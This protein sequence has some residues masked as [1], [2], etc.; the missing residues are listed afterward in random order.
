[1]PD[2][3]HPFPMRSLSRRRFLLAAG[4]GLALSMVAACRGG[5]FSLRPEPTLEPLDL[6]LLVAEEFNFLFDLSSFHDPWNEAFPHWPLTIHEGNWNNL[7]ERV[8]QDAAQGQASFDGVLP[9]AM[10]INTFDWLDRDLLQPVDPHF[11]TSDIPGADRLQSDLY[12][13]VRDA[14]QEQGQ[15]QGIP[16]NV[17][18]VALAWLTAPLAEAGVTAPPVTWDDTQAA[19]QAVQAATSL[20]PYDRALSP[21]SDLLAMIWSGEAD[22][23]TVD[24]LVNWSG[25]TAVFAVQWLQDMVW[26]ELMP[27]TERGFDLWMSGR[28]A[29]LSSLDLM[30]PLAASFLGEGTVVTGSNMRLYREEARAGTPFWTNTLAL[31]RGAPN[32]AAA[33]AFAFWW[34]GP[35]NIGHQRRIADVA[36]KPAYTYVFDSDLMADAK[37]DW[38]REAMT[39][40]GASVRLQTGST[41]NQELEAVVGWLNRALD[42][43][44]NLSAQEAMQAAMSEVR[45]IRGTA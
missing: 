1:M 4:S 41:W 23:Y 20:V 3:Q 28:I 7:L 36:A 19:A 9:V 27:A 29:M 2:T 16:V 15:M 6:N 30:G 24:G 26:S 18:S 11:E 45:G 39:A 17:S 33:A 21:V 34:L 44:E 25:E 14:V 22:P 12:A 43:D 8:M 31:L 13:A 35:E 38:Q 37:Y 40:V 42:W 32:A 5:R 10:P